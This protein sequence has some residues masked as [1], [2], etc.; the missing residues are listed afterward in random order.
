MTDTAPIPPP[1]PAP[2]EHLS[3]VVMGVSGSGKST[4][5]VAVAKALRLGFED[6]DDL[7]PHANVEKMSAGIP[8]TDDDRWPWLDRVGTVL[9]DVA[10][11]PSGVVVAC[12]AL[13]RAYRARIRTAAA[14][15][16]RFLYLEAD[17]DEMVRRLRARPHHYM[18]PSLVDSQFATL[19]P[20][21]GERDVLTIPASGPLD[22]HVAAAVAWLSTALP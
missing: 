11:Y 7:H 19:E 20:P 9:A 21:E 18:P 10:T 12:S 17:R 4:L 15:P 16:V 14:G 6:G 3:V 1:P 22:A 13:R 8:L 2:G 5:G